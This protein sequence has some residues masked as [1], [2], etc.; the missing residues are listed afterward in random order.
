MSSERVAALSLTC[1]CSDRDCR[2]QRPAKGGSRTAPLT[3]N[4]AARSIAARLKFAVRYAISA[5]A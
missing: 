1:M 3:L 4:L 2:C 5:V